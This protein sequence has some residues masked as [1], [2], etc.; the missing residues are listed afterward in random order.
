MSG[1]N[2]NYFPNDEKALV[3]ERN[4]RQKGHPNY[5]TDVSTMKDQLVAQNVEILTE[6]YFKRREDMAFGQEISVMPERFY[7]WRIIL[8]RR[9]S[10]AYK[11]KSFSEEYSR[12]WK[13]VYSL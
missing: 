12:T 11:F 3:A 13:E 6:E 10:G 1:K 7:A 5:F 4:A 9:D 8:R 2:T